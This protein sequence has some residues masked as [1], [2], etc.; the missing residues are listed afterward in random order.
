MSSSSVELDREAEE[1]GLSLSRSL[2]VA[3]LL[4][5]A[6]QAVPYGWGGA[7]PPVERE[8]PW[9]A[10]ATRELLFRACR[11]GHSHETSWPWYSRVAPASW[12]V[13][14][15]VEEGR[16]HFKVSR[17]GSGRQEADEAAEMLREGEMPLCYY[18]PFHP[19]ARLS[20]AERERL[21]AGLVATFGDVDEGGR[22]RRRRRRGGGS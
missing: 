7:N 3:G 1:V 10:P 12:L 21:I 8:P 19:G 2:F 15:D 20:A 18:L 9:D 11:D 13:R 5:L 22:R 14:R 16:S 4:L 17:W 6:I